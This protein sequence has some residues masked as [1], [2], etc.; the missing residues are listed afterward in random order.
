MVVALLTLELFIPGA[1][2]LK[3]KRMVLRRIK[4]RVRKFNIAVS[5]VEHQD[6]WQRAALAVVTVST[7]QAHADRELAAVA[8]EIERVEPGLITRTGIEFLT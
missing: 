8:D 4:D 3:D 6:L 2:S 1:Q 7:D 5:E